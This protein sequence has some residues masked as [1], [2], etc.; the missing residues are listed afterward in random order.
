MHSLMTI[1]QRRPGILPV[2]AG[3]VCLTVLFTVAGSTTVDAS[4]SAT[5]DIEMEGDGTDADPYVI[6]DLEELQAME[7]ELDAHYVLGTDI[8]A[9]ET[10]SWE[11]GAG[12]DPIGD[13]DENEPF[14]G[15]LDGNGYT[16][17]DLT[18]D[19]PTRNGVGL[20][21]YSR[22][23]TIE[24]VTLESVSVNGGADVGTVIGEAQASSIS[25][26]VVSGTVQGTDK[27]VGGLVGSN[28]GQIS[29]ASM[30]GDVHGT[31]EEVGGLVGSN[32]GPIDESYTAVTV[33]GTEDVGGLV[34]RNDG[35]VRAS[36]AAGSVTGEEI[37][38]GLGGSNGD[39]INDAYSVAAVTG[40]DGVGGLIGSHSGTVT[41]SYAAG[42][43]ASDSDKGGFVAYNEGIITDSYWDINETGQTSPYAVDDDGDVTGYESHKLTGPNATTVTTFDFESTWQQTEVYPRLQWETQRS[44]DE[45]ASKLDV[46]T[47][48][49]EPDLESAQDDDGLLPVSWSVLIGTLAGFSI[50]CTVAAA[51]V[52]VRGGGIA[53][54]LAGGRSNQWDPVVTRRTESIAPTNNSST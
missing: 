46:E 22:E 14:T 52:I 1:Q 28:D 51:V 3:V 6:T 31:G 49:P 10:A 4:R 47:E 25:G 54:V 44:V 16:I 19:R 23:G 17:A 30:V 45:R 34:G 11:G 26:V 53:R 27:A 20:I 38:G 5:V 39:A 8:D 36:F 32:S 24:A 42:S 43:V 18:I 33:D 12:F 37:V 9:S 48:P 2:L 15:S 40:D 35:P 13:A 50:L 41:T 29:R 7:A 21:A